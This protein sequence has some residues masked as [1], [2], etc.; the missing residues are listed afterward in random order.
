M[1]NPPEPSA[2]ELAIRNITT[3]TEANRFLETEYKAIYNRRFAV[4]AAQD[5]LFVPLINPDK[6]DDILCVKH[7]RKTDN[8]GT[9]SFKGRCFQILDKG[10]PIIS[11]AKA[12]QV[13]IS[14]RSGIRVVYNGHTFET[15]RYLKPQN[16]TT[17]KK[18]KKKPVTPMIPLGSY[19][20]DA[21]KRIWWSE[22]YNESMQ[23]LYEL[24]FKQQQTIS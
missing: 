14:P 16:A 8:A 3:V 23:F 4:A 9:F 15:I 17:R 6:I 13:L 11:K 10:F 19:G 5:S 24:F 22:D 1:G 18:P 7:E 2:V 21:W 12:I 20:T